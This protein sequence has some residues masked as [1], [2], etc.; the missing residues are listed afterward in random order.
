MDIE[1]FRRTIHRIPWASR[2]EAASAIRQQVE[3]TGDT[4]STEGQYLFVAKFVPR[5]LAMLLPNFRVQT[6][7]DMD[8][9]ENAL[10]SEPTGHY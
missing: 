10:R 1:Y 4:A 3:G 5:R 2:M 8:A 6:P 7:A 9:L